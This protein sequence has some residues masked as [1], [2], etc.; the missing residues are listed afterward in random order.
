MP[1]ATELRTWA[2]ANLAPEIRRTA[3][4]EKRLGVSDWADRY[5]ELDP[6]N[7]SMPGPW[8]TDFSPFLR[9][10]LDTYS[11]DTCEDLVLMGG[12]QWGKTESMIN[13]LLWTIDQDPMPALVVLPTEDDV[14]SFGTRRLKVACEHSTKIAERRTGWKRDWKVNEL[15]FENMVVYL[16]WSGSASKL[17]SR[18]IGRLFLDEVDKYEEFTGK[19][20]D[21]ISLATERLRWWKNSR[22]VIASTPTTTDGYIWS[23]W[24]NSDR[25]WFW[26]PCPHCRKYQRLVFD[27]DTVRVP[28]GERDPDRIRMHRL[29]VYVCRKCGKDIPDRDDV[30]REMLLAGVWVPDGGRV[31]PSGNVAGVKLDALS[32]G[33]HVNALYSPMLS[34]SDV[35]AKFFEAKDDLRKYMNFVNSWVGWPWIQQAEENTIDAL[36]K[37][38][39]EHERGEV[40]DWVIVQT[41]GVDVQKD[42]LYWEVWGWGIG[43]RCALIDFGRC[44]R[45]EDL[46]HELFDMRPVRTA[47]VDSGYRTDEVYRFVERWA[48]RAK[49][50]KGQ[51]KL[52]TPLRSVKLQRDYGGRAGGLVLWHV[53]TGYFKDKIVRCRNADRGAPGSV[54]LF[55]DPPDEWLRQQTSEHKVLVRNR[56]T[57]TIKEAWTEKPGGGGNHWWDCSVYAYA[58]AEM[59]GVYKLRGDDERTAR[60]SEDMTA[61]IKRAKTYIRKVRRKGFIRKR[62][63]R[64]E[65]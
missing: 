54:V 25:R 35:L 64:P 56:S 58:A 53:D 10:I 46:E 34:W 61:E 50:V 45:F 8:R 6:I 65:E 1:K 19:E 41:A 9:G 63:E 23:E 44:E 2:A 62:G 47:A 20:S 27:F 40:P 5:R 39:G 30:K 22:R 36:R 31:T 21:P 16:G 14:T 11:D 37:L 42:L 4:P 28:K 15:G 33:F 17:A 13:M 51:A 18:S 12:T 32:R 29:A 49:P 57:R 26:V 43:E 24:N 3:R 55:D 38:E 52:A 7:C 59:L 60:V 48:D